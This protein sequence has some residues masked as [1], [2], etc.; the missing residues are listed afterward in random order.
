M[1]PRRLSLSLALMCAACGSNND[2]K[3]GSLDGGSAPEGGST[4]QAQ[5]IAVV[6]SDYKSA[7]VSLLASTA[8]GLTVTKADCITSG[9]KAP[10]LSATLSADVVLPSRPQPKNELVI[11]DRGNSAITWLDPG[12]CAVK[13]QLS[14]GSGFASNPYDVATVTEHKAYVPRYNQNPKDEAEGSDLVVIDPTTAELKG[15]IDLRPYATKGDKPILARPARVIVVDD[16]AYVLLNNLSADFKAAGAGRIVIVDPATDTVTGMI[17]LP[18]LK[19]CSTM[20]FVAEDK[21]LAVSC[22]GLFGD[23]QQL[24]ES[25]V[26]WVDLE[27]NPPTVRTTAGSTFG[28]AVSP[29]DAAG[30]TPWQ[31]YTIVP[32]DFKG[33]PPDEL[34]EYNFGNGNARKI[35]EATGGFVLGGLLFDSVNKRLLMADAADKMPLVRSFDFAEVLPARGPTVTATPTG[36]PPRTLAWY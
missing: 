32:G 12:T 28:R 5:G 20:A 8:A 14:L 31:I 21:A 10:Q 35:A 15:R 18:T 2:S 29:N 27:T 33:T 36:L 3:T 7:S 22:G 26:A 16:K 34:W 6:S 13:R 30:A 19:N 23:P 1:T 11:I 9:T 24:A 17:D 4:L 25:G